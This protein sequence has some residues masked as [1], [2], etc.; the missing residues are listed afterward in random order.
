[1]SDQARLY[2]NWI[3]ASPFGTASLFA[4]RSGAW[5]F[6]HSVMQW[7]TGSKNSDRLYSRAEVLNFVVKDFET[8][9]DTH[10]TTT[11]GFD[12]PPTN[13]M[14]SGSIDVNRAIYAAAQRF[15][16]CSW[17]DSAVAQHDFYIGYWQTA[18]GIGERLGFNAA[19]RTASTKAGAVLDWMI[20]QHRKRVVGRINSAPR[21]NPGGDADYLFYLWKSSTITAASGNVASLPLTYAAIATQNGN[22]ATW[23]VFQF[24][25]TTYSKDGQA[26]DQL[27]AGPSVLR[28][29]LGQSG[30]D[31]TSAETT[32]TSWRNQK[33]TQQQALGANGA[34]TTW[35]RYLQAV[36]NP[37]IS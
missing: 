6:L 32:A 13:I 22:A 7:K 19:L 14:V 3:L 5:Q 2:E 36:H 26:M 33:K 21:A 23:D 12:N 31:L 37:A 15:G 30:S 18:L 35:F 27:I 24:G 10:K 20:A 11:P 16:V 4:E 34:G 28:I 17:E 25:G 29:H 9:S 1:M 8:F